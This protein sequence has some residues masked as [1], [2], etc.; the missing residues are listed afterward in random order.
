MF[1]N[2]LSYIIKS[3]KNEISGIQKISASLSLYKY[4]NLSFK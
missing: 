2:G 4:H 3:V 1:N